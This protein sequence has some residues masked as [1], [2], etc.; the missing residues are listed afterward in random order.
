VTD[1]LIDGILRES[2]EVR[3]AG[4]DPELVDF[5]RPRFPRTRY[6]AAA[7]LL[8]PSGRVLDVGCGAGYMLY[9]LRD[10]FEELVGID[11]VRERV[12]RANAAFSRRG[13]DATIVTGSLESGLPW[14]DGHFDAVVW[15]DVVQ[16]VPNLWAGFDEIARVLR[17]GGQLVTTAPN[18]AYVKRIFSLLRGRF[19][20]TSAPD[21]GLA[22]RDG[23]WYDDGTFHYF[24]FSSMKKLYRHAG[25]APDKAIGY[26]RL[27][28]P[29]QVRPELFSGGIVLSGTKRE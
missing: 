3:Y 4:V 18:F 25:I 19:P 17:P 9:N 26:G 20:A 13:I 23:V 10:A 11:F 14:D 15:T 6:Q 22:V 27:G 1:S 8:R 24:T 12:E 2:S 28:F 7:Q 29:H 21:E 16:L 5:A